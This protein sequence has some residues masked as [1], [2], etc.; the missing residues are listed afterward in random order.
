MTDIDTRT[1][2]DK[3]GRIIMLKIAQ[4]YNKRIKHT[5]TKKPFL[6]P[7]LQQKKHLLYLSIF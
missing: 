4:S 1:E 2:T 7:L 3:E 6:S 5:Y